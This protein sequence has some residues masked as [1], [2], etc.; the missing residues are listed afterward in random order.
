MKSSFYF[1][2]D[3]DARE[4]DKIRALIYR[5]GATGY[6]IYWMLVEDLY[7]NK[8]RLNRDYAVLARAYRQPQL[9]VKAVV[10]EYAAFYDA[11]GKIACR[12]VDR[13]LVSRRESSEKASKAG[14]ISAAQRAL[15]KRSTVSQPGEERR[16]KEG[17]ERETT[18][19]P[20][21]FE[22]Q[23]Y[24]K[25]NGGAVDPE[26]FYSVNSAT[27]WMIRGTP[28]KDWRALLA[29]WEKTEKRE[30]PRLAEE[31]KKKKCQNPEGCGLAGNWIA[32]K[33]VGGDELCAA[34]LNEEAVK[35]ERA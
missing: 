21:L 23:E 24:V 17:K 3:L 2:H 15:N 8:G 16:G 34:C 9:K 33:G 28:I 27:G 31:L 22:I 13:D 35:L 19:A 12:R 11:K 32:G 30:S 7:R 5:H 4:D 25:S 29:S 18:G 10:E 6:G 26:R 14:K 20:S 1:K